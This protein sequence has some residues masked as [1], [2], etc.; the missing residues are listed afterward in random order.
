MADRRQSFSFRFWPARRTPSP[1]PPQPT[2]TARPSTVSQPVPRQSTTSTTA[3]PTPQT[4]TQPPPRTTNSAPATIPAAQSQPVNNS[5]TSPKAQTPPSPPPPATTNSTPTAGQIAESLPVSRRPTTNTT[6]ISP[7]TTE[8]QT[9]PPPTTTNSAPISTPTPEKSQANS[10]QSTTTA[11][12]P[13]PTKKTG[14]P[15]QNLTSPGTPTLD[16]KTTPPIEKQASSQ[17]TTTSRIDEPKTSSPSSPT[18]KSP[19]SSNPIASPSRRTPQS[20]SPPMHSSPSRPSPQAQP[21]KSSSPSR[22]SKTPS[23]PQR[24]SQPRSPS[25]LT[26]KQITSNSTPKESRQ[27]AQP[28]SSN[29]EDSKPATTTQENPQINKTNGVEETMF[30]HKSNGNTT[31]TAEESDIPT[32][33]GESGPHIE[34]KAKPK[35]TKDVQEVGEA[36]NI[37]EANEETKKEVNGFL[38]PTDG[39]IIEKSEIPNKSKEAHT[40]KLKEVLEREEVLHTKKRSMNLHDKPA[41]TFNKGI[42]DDISTFVKQTGIGDHS[43]NERNVSIIT[44]AGENRGA[45]MQMGSTSKEGRVHIHRGYKKVNPGKSGELTTSDEEGNFKGERLKDAKAA[46]DQPTEAYVNNNAQGINNSIVFNA[47]IAER[48]P[49]VHMVVT[50]VPREP[51]SPA[52][53]KLSPFETRKAEFNMSRSEKLTYEEP[54]VRRRCLKGLFLETSDSDP[55]NSEKPR[56]HG[57][58]VGCKV[59]EK[60]NSIE[61][62]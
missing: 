55:E 29:E 4:R 6:S 11:T 32:I 45:S 60:E 57:C 12:P 13:P 22:N 28:S 26:S 2:P 19:T 59:K 49:G 14:N 51:I 17:P 50:H 44:L 18:T 1:S 9:P 27:I 46:E 43:T 42:K 61:K 5:T 3:P 53:R 34:L 56:R 36:T 35:E 48:D 15:P 62:I 52:E 20:K 54:T 21:I 25:R 58:R 41:P 10:R 47:S 33:N 24:T 8:S 23:T 37:K 7:P 31:T 38:N 16:P 39:P 30:K 40:E